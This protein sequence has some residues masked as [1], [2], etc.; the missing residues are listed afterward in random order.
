MPLKK[1]AM[2]KYSYLL[3]LTLSLCQQSVFAQSNTY[4]SPVSIVNYTV[5]IDVQPS[6]RYTRT[7]EHAT[8]IE[9]EY[10]ADNHG[11]HRYYNIGSQETIRILDAYT[12]APDGKRTPLSP[13]WIKKNHRTKSAS[14]SDVND[15][16]VTTVIFPNVT[17]GSSLYSK[18]RITRHTPSYPREF[19]TE[20]RLKP[21]FKY[22][23][24]ELS[25]T[26]QK[27]MPLFVKNRGFEGGV[28]S[29][30]G[31]KQTFRFTGHQEQAYPDEDNQIDAADFSP[32]IVISTFENHVA[33]GNAYQRD[34]HRM[35]KF[36][37]AITALSQQLTT[38]LTT[39]SDKTH[40]LYNWVTK[41]IRYVSAR[42]GNERL[43][44]HRAAD[45]LRNRFGDCKDHVALLESLLN[46]AGIV[47]TPALV[48]S[49]ESFELSGA[50]SFNPLNHV[51]TYVPSLDL[52][53]DSTAQF[54]PYGTLPVSV[55]DK[56]VVLTALGKLGHTPAMR[57]ADNTVFTKVKMTV[58]PDGHAEGETVASMTGTLQID[59]RSSRFQSQSEAPE[60]TVRDLLFRFNEIGEGKM[61]YTPPLA[62]D[63]TYQVNSSFSLEP[64]AAMPGTGAFS[65]PVGL[66][67]GRIASMASFQ[68]HKKRQFNYVCDSHIDEDEYILHLPTNI[69]VMH[70]PKDVALIDPA[71]SYTAQY[72]LEGSQ[73]TVKRRLAIQRDGRVCTPADHE[74]WKE[75]IK[76]IRL[77]L[78][79]QVFFQ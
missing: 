7:I 51:I 16:N 29:L 5:K 3:A 42:I 66:A 26:A 63:E 75:T 32:T 46:A 31:N 27:S 8:R 58:F 59:S 78:R 19:G 50:A 23:H 70:I 45:V 6:G 2:K 38:G 60:I 64:L 61:T 1:T 14:N 41:N 17:V 62:L 73:L 12:I 9:S 30:H 20:L 74:K 53:L 21:G 43:V 15:T 55:L 79:S 77:D 56:P 57:A 24:A 47:S 71:V 52:Y 25:V 35:A 34:A 69:Q 28:V 67:P 49:G 13:G 72:Q 48:N 11:S 18:A 22:Q 76:L 65:I 54:A 36:T 68:Q 4:E 10:G 40:A 44:P 33:A 37:P 39:E